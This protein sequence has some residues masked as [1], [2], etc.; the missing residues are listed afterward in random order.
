MTQN[1][2]KLYGIDFGKPVFP[3]SSLILLS[4]NKLIMHINKS[5]S[6]THKPSRLL[7]NLLSIKEEQQIEGYLPT[8]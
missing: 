4:M 7:I 8:N 2:D 1:V 5:L 3:W 6:L